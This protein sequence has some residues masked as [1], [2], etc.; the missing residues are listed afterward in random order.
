MLLVTASSSAKGATEVMLGAIKAVGALGFMLSTGLLINALEVCTL[1]IRP[2]SF[3]TFRKANKM[4]IN[5][6]W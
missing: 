3:Q 4:L 5:V 6:H 1:V 2:F